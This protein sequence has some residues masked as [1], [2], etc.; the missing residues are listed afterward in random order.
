MSCCCYYYYYYSSRND[1]CS[2]LPPSFAFQGPRCQADRDL[3]KA[4]LQRLLSDDSVVPGLGIVEDGAEDLVLEPVDGSVLSSSAPSQRVAG[5][6]TSSGAVIR[7]SKVVITTGTFLRGMIHLGLERYPA[8]RH[9]RDRYV[10]LLA[11]RFVCL[12]VARRAA[13]KL[14]VT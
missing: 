6:V 2:P 9:K 3:Y 11:L 12:R 4:A 8:G 10:C 1:V 13:V 14:C 5:V 7:A